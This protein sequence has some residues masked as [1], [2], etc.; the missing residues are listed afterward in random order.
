MVPNDIRGDTTPKKRK[1][2]R[3]IHKY[4]QKLSREVAGVIK[5]S[6]SAVST[7]I[8]RFIETGTAFSPA[9]N[10]SLA[11]KIKNGPQSLK[12]LQEVIIMIH[13]L[14]VADLK[15]S[16]RSKTRH[17][18]LWYFSSYTSIKRHR[19]K[20]GRVAQ[21]PKQGSCSQKNEK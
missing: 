7:I 3:T 20:A 13:R 19:I 15:I 9:K 18:E 14:S 17:D 5:V 8:L 6:L 4:C 16:R 11:K 1:R 10:D 12:L 2:I 21:A